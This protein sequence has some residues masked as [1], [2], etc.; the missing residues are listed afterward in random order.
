MTL[1]ALAI[2][3]TLAGSLLLMAVILLTRDNFL[4]SSVLFIAFGLFTALTWV[5]LGAPDIALAEAAIG[6][7]VTGVLLMDAIRHMEWEKNT[8]S[9]KWLRSRRSGEAPSLWMKVGFSGV[10]MF[11]GVLLVGAVGQMGDQR[12]GLAGEAAQRMQDLENPVTAVLL[13]FRGLD[14]WLELGILLLAVLGML[15]VR[16][17]H[18]LQAILLAPPRDPILEG[19][20]QLLAPLAILTAAYFLWLGTFS[21]GGAFQSGVV[22]GATGMLLWLSGHSSINAFPQWLWKLLMLLGFSVFC[23]AAAI[24]LFVSDWM[25]QFPAYFR[26]YFIVIIEAAAAVSIGACLAGLFVGQHPGWD[27]FNRDSKGG[28]QPEQS[29]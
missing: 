27:A 9:R 16:E 1:A 19:G 21:A 29:R 28:E 20:V 23:L 15:T 3:L 7:G 10:T 17:R 26:H 8:F 18:G 13:V 2:D 5:R 14:T 25:L 6:A 24:T 4:Q 22:L 12:P 11:I